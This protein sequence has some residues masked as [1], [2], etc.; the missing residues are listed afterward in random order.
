ML[1]RVLDSYAI[2]RLQTWDPQ[3]IAPSKIE[4]MLGVA[5]PRQ[6]GAVASGGRADILCTGPTDWLA[7]STTCEATALALQLPEA[8]EG[9]TYRATNVSQALACIEIQGPSVRELL[10]KGCALDLHPSHFPPGRCARTRFAALP[11]LIHCTQ[12]ATFRCIVTSS[13]RDYLLSWLTDAAEEL[14]GTAA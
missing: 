3:A 13:C 14:L 12:P 5:W 7:I 10:L 2:F 9:C 4:Q 6:V 1:S 8:C 11:V